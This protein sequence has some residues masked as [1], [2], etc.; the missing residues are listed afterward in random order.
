MAA[1]LA[2]WYPRM[3]E[4]QPEIEWSSQHS[5]GAA[6]G[7]KNRAK[8]LNANFFQA[9]AAAA[10]FDYAAEIDLRL[11]E[12]T[13]RNF[14][15]DSLTI[16]GRYL[17]ADDVSGA[18]PFSAIATLSVSSAART[19][20]RDLTS[21]HHGKLEGIL[22][23]SVGK[24]SACGQFWTS[25]YWGTVGLGMADVG[26]PWLH[27]RLCAEIN[28][29]DRHSG[30]IF[31]DGLVGFG[32]K[33]LSLHHFKGYGPIA[34][35]SLDVGLNYKYAFEMGLNVDIGYSYRLVARNFP[36]HTNNFYLALGY[37]FGL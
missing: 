31:V 6:C 36:K 23:L 22:H 2:P 1:V 15:Y 14:G 9:S 20:V 19:A 21:F 4:I 18:S 3:F 7:H 27:A 5:N 13:Y 33:D 32:Q 35:R 17:L 12:S 11:A 28:H 24:E 10:V 26:S 16:S 29:M 37:P 8:S 30:L 25:R 34:H